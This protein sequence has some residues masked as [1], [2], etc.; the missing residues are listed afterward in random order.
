MH[1]YRIDIPLI[2]GRPKRPPRH[3]PGFQGGAIMRRGIKGEQ[4]VEPASE[5]S[6]ESAPT[7]AEQVDQS[8]ETKSR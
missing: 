8:T 7:Q 6:T 4:S 2:Q 1:E 5:A 3:A